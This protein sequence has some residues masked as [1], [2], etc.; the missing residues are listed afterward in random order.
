VSLGVRSYPILIGKGLIE[1][2]P[3]HLLQHLGGA[4]FAIVA[5]EAVG[6]LAETLGTGLAK[7]GLLLGP[8]CFVP[9]GESSKSF[10]RLQSVCSALLDL[11]LERN[12][13]VI[14]LG[15]G[16]IGDLAGFAAAILKRGVRL[17]QIPTTLLAQVD[18]SVGGKTGINAGQGK[19]LIGA[20]H[21]PSLVLADLSSLKTLPP[22]EFRA[23]YAEIVKYG[24]LGDAAFFDWLEKNWER[25]FA[26][27]EEALTHAVEVS[28]RMKADIVAR[29]EFETGDRALLNLGHTFGHAVEAWAGYSGKVLHGEAVA[30]GMMLAAQFSHRQGLCDK[31]V[32]ERLGAHLA[33]CG[34]ATSFTAS[35]EGNAANLRSQIGALPTVRE[36]LHFMEQDKKVRDGQMTFILLRSIGQAFVAR[37]VDRGQIASFLE[38]QL[39]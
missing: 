10:A 4:R 39:T 20:F 35:G 27:E 34:F 23:G 9:S 7:H 17:V 1:A 32:P 30:L 36:L 12:H 26:Q 15:G 13:A 37:N 29:D 24:A 8:T 31:S 38:G 2:A 33:N 25:V 19:N 11:G 22:R 14:A 6:A 16:V 21:Q 28:C 18:S 5:D 3:Q